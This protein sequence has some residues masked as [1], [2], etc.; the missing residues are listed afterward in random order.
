MTPVEGGCR[1]SEHRGPRRQISAAR[2]GGDEFAVILAADVSPHEASA[3]AR[4]AVDMLKAPYEI[5]GQEMVI[6]AS[7]GIALAPSDGTTSES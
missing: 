1:P 5:D 6:G 4:L 7:I 3:C 2:L